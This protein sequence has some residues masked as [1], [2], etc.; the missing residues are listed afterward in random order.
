MALLVY[1]V[2]ADDLGGQERFH[3][4][5]VGLGAGEAG[6]ARAGE[7]NL[8][9]GGELK[10]QVGMPGLRAEGQD[11]WEGHVVPLELVDAV[12]VVPH[13]E[14]VRRG[15]GQ[16]RQA[17]DGILRVDDALGIGVLGDAPD[18]LDGGVLDGLLHGVHVGAGLCH[19]DG[20][21][22]KAEGLR[23]FEVAVVTR[24]GAEPLDGFLFAPGPGAVEH[25][26]GVGLGDGVV[27]ELEAGIAPREDLL[28]LAA[29][30]VREELPGG[31]EAPHLSIVPHVHAAGD[32]ILGV[33]HQAEDVTGQ[34]QLLLPGLAPG[35][36]QAE[37][38]GLQRV[39]S[40]LQ[41]GI[42]PVPLRRGEGGV[43]LH[44]NPSFLSV[45]SIRF[46]IAN[47]EGGFK[48]LFRGGRTRS[49]IPRPMGKSRKSGR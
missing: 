44:K 38:L 33:L 39:K 1:L 41:A 13:D 17:A 9:R 49:A 45:G 19:G 7:G 46:S 18:A 11:V 22:L 47:T 8:R 43:R 5:H 34:V 15:G 6:H 30:D 35:H 16:G 42:L 20:G 3:V 31:G 25:S 40:A 23:D 32:I 14:E 28:R 4:G 27:H 2:E 10:H 37:A 48:S 36:V 24:G 26:V 12:G 29:Q 21:Q